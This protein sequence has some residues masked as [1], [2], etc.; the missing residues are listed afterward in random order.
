MKNKSTVL[1]VLAVLGVSFA[2]AGCVVHPRHRP[3]WPHPH[4]P[5]H[6]HHL[7]AP[8]DSLSP[9]QRPS[10]VAMLSTRTPENLRYFE[11]IV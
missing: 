11:Y 7:Q 9:V 8:V 2:F 6:R 10:N 4:H 5:H 1:A 3:H